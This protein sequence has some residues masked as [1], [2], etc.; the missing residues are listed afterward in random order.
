MPTACKPDGL[1][2]KQSNNGTHKGWMVTGTA[3]NILVLIGW[4]QIFQFSYTTCLSVVRGSWLT[5]SWVED[6]NIESVATLK[7][8]LKSSYFRGCGAVIC[9]SAPYKRRYRVSPTM[10]NAFMLFWIRGVGT[11]TAGAALAAPLFSIKKNGKKMGKKKWKEEE[12]EEKKTGKKWRE[13][14]SIYSLTFIHE[15]VYIS[16]KFYGLNETCIHLQDWRIFFFFFF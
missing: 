6:E 13:K 15:T 16:W 3:Q 14:K 11:A 7:S 1:R 8:Y 10:H 2:C 12:E 9:C 5:A 4:M